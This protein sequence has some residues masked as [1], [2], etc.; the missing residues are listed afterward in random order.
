MFV[1]V[2][3][4]HTVDGSEILQRLRLVVYLIHRRFLPDES[5]CQ[6]NLKFCENLFVVLSLPKDIQRLNLEL[7]DNIQSYYVRKTHL[8]HH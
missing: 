1:S 8:S 2:F 3:H 5:S 6:V 7:H 4:C